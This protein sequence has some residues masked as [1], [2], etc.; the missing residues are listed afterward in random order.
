MIKSGGTSCT[1][2]WYAPEAHTA[3]PGVGSDTDFY[4]YVTAGNDV[5][6]KIKYI[7]IK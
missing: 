3:E 4:V 6:C 5:D 1:E 2:N 7:I